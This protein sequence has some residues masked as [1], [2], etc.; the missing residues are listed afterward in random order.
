MLYTNLI[1]AT[2][3]VEQYKGVLVFLHGLLGDGND[4]KSVID[5]L[6]DFPV[7]TVDL[8][9]HGNSRTICC[10]GFEQCCEL[11]QNA[12][13]PVLTALP[14]P[15]P[16]FLIGYSLGARVCMYGLAQ[17]CFTELDIAGCLLEGGNFGLSS[18]EEKQMR[19]ENDRKWAER[20][21]TEPIEQVLSDWYCQSVFSS[22]NPQQR[23][24]SV[25]KRSHN[26]GQAVAQMLMATSLAKQPY[27]LNKIKNSKIPI[28]Y[29][30]GEKDRKFSEL[31]EQSGLS[32]TR[33]EDAGHNA[34]SEQP[35]QYAQL[36]R[37]LVTHIQTRH[38][39]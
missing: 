16:V 4:W 21:K 22:L 26:Q 5:E 24:T 34:H 33:V 39:E 30:C 29:L 35:F 27:L 15:V 13:L 25:V 17:N 19:L 28:H 31:A 18:E 8:P 32:F 1:Q 10:D 2:T 23:Q 6:T 3:G 9:G 36:I 12:I 20:F 14:K 38:L 7:L 11:V 37:T